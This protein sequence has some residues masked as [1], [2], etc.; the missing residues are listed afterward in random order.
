[1][2]LAAEVALRLGLPGLGSELVRTPA[3]AP[4]SQFLLTHEVGY[5]YKPHVTIDVLSNGISCIEHLNNEGFRGPEYS[6]E[7][8]QG[9][10][11]ILSIGDSIVEGFMFPGRDVPFGQT[12]QQVLQRSLNEAATRNGGTN[13]YEVINA[14]IG[15][16]VSWQTAVRLANRGLKYDPDLVLVFV[17]WNDLAYS[18]LPHWKPGMDLT[19]LQ[20]PSSTD[21]TE[22]NGRPSSF[23]SRLRQSLYHASYVARLVRQ[24]RNNLRNR[25]VEAQLTRRKDSGLPFNEAA[26]KLYLE[27]L[28]TMYR[29]CSANKV[30]MGL[31][32]WPT[33][34]SPELL[35]DEEV[36]KKL[37]FSFSIFPLSARDTWAWYQRYIEAQRDFA[38]RHQDV[39]LVDAPA[40]FVEKSKP[41]RL[42]L[43]TDLGHLT[44][45]G[46][47]RLAD[48]CR[49]A[50]LEAGVVQ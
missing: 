19:S 15:G 20:S 10:M 42:A 2:F 18:S 40:A 23:W 26:L 41:A 25:T 50:L 28:E 14:G 39:L 49:R 35:D 16:Y 17:G 45:E 9:T 22:P 32:L 1:V 48:A 47:Q 21:S 5:E 11:R 46:N 29:A 24:A 13:R 27:N 4:K 12:W 34:L 30:R 36:K 6:I 33:L 38:A 44:P 8:P 31:V 43:F 3:S 7:K 37:R